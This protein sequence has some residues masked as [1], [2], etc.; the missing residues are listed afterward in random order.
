MAVSKRWEGV[1]MAKWSWGAWRAGLIQ[2]HT[3]AVTEE[4]PLI[5]CLVVMY[6]YSEIEPGILQQLKRHSHRFPISTRVA[7]ILTPHPEITS[8]SG[9]CVLSCF[10]HTIHQVLHSVTVET[11]HSMYT[12]SNHCSP[13][14]LPAP[15]LP[16]TL[17]YFLPL[18][19]SFFQLPSR[20]SMT[21]HPSPSFVHHAHTHVHDP[22]PAAI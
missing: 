3:H 13:P 12:H 17:S 2:Y 10:C 8:N 19:L 9:F 22:P 11:T 1:G 6:Q 18:F 5:S 21:S 14:P 15:F 20:L 16:S 4:D 7:R